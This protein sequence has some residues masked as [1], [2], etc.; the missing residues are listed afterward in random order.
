[1]ALLSAVIGLMLLY[2]ACGFALRP[3][4]DL[5]FVKRQTATSD[6]KLVNCL[7]NKLTEGTVSS[8]CVQ[9]I[10]NAGA[11]M[12]AEYAIVCSSTCDSLYPAIVACAGADAT[13]ELYREV[14]TNGY[15]VPG[16]GI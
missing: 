11:D 12:A 13:R 8:D 9:G 4:S 16:S 5:L 3:A 2:G 15:T 6:P 1:M 7:R 14:C 10:A